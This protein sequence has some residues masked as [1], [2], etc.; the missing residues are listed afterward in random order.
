MQ[1]SAPKKRGPKPGATGKHLWKKGQSGNPAGKPTEKVIDP[2]TGQIV[3]L[4]ELAR[5][6]TKEAF[7][8]LSASMRSDD[9]RVAVAAAE[10]ILSRGWGKAPQSVT[11]EDGEGPVKH[12]ITVSFK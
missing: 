10:A 2:A 3:S 7:D 1:D 9:E 5:S 12:K 4:R 6:Y 11:G 8:V